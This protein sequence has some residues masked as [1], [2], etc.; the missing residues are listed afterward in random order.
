MT[1]ISSNW[2]AYYKTGFPVFWFGFLALFLAAAIF[3]GDIS[4]KP[5]FLLVPIAMAVFGFFLMK[6]LVWDLVDEVYDCGEALLVKNR[7]EETL[8][9]LSNIMNV[10][11]SSFQNP[12]RITLRLI[13][14]GTFGNAIAFL[15]IL[16]FRLNPFAKI[17]VAEDLIVRVH[18]AKGGRAA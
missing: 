9:P 16:G 17:Q 5:M 10:S 7:G 11:V 6:M 2:T 8:V 4:S 3:G 18:R 14:S 12:P 1:K 15:P 13:N